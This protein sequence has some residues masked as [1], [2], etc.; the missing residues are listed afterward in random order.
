F[1]QDYA[2][3]NLRFAGTFCGVARNVMTSAAEATSENID[4]MQHEA[5]D[6]VHKG[7]EQMG[8]MAQDANNYAQ[9]PIH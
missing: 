9:E 8:Q 5:S 6:M 1:L 4:R 7:G 2:S 3:Q